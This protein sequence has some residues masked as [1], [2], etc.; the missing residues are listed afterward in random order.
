MADE[1]KIETTQATPNKDTHSK[2][3]SQKGARDQKKA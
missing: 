2:D 1:K 3:A